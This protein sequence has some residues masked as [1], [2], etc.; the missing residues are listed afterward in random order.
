[1]SPEAR[2]GKAAL[3]RLRSL[4][5]MIVLMLLAISV[6]IWSL[7]SR[8]PFLR[9][10]DSASE[11]NPERRIDGESRAE[12]KVGF[13]HREL[14]AENKEEFDSPKHQR[15]SEFADIFNI[16]WSP[17]GF[18]P[19]TDKGER[20]RWVRIV[21]VDQGNVSDLYGRI[22]CDLWFEIE[23][24][25]TIPWVRVEELRAVVKKYDPKLPD[26]P[27]WVIGRSVEQ[28]NVYYV[29]ID[30][31]NKAGTSIFTANFLS[32]DSSIDNPRKMKQTPFRF[33]RLTSGKPEAFVLRVNA[34]SP[35]IYTFSC[36]A[37]ISYK[38]RRE[39]CSLSEDITLHFSH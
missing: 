20:I 21:E 19:N 22:R 18:Q 9:I 29:E 39:Q 33:V 8:F 28:L 25:K 34:V 13:D 1:M 6:T 24:K 15:P 32:E 12:N 10:N 38:G 7:Y 35:G 30:D 17:R 26:V 16:R 31:P 2:P 23:P 14:Q 36:D 3:L 4:S 5:A 11:R 27:K 37:V